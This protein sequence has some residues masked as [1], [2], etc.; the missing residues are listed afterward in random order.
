[1]ISAST[2]TSSLL[3]DPLQ[4]LF[5]STSENKNE[6][7]AQRHSIDKDLESAFA[8]L[9]A[10]VA[11]N[12][13]VM[14]NE[15]IM[16]LFNKSQSTIITPPSVNQHPNGIFTAEDSERINYSAIHCFFSSFTF[17]LCLPNFHTA[18]PI[19]STAKVRLYHCQFVPTRWS[20]R[21]TSSCK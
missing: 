4:E 7:H 10:C 5:I 19:H 6:V 21:T 14:S 13:G 16:A 12:D 9:N 18:F 2:T 20:Y 8:P 3:L 11:K 1:M 17:D 15:K